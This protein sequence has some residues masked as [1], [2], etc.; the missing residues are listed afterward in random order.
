[1]SAARALAHHCSGCQ[2][3]AP[4]RR[5]TSLGAAS[6]VSLRRHVP[7]QPQ[8][9]TQS[10]QIW[11]SASLP[12]APAHTP[13]NAAGD[14]EVCNAAARKLLQ[15]ADSNL[16]AIRQWYCDVASVRAILHKACSWGRRRQRRKRHVHRRRR[17]LHER[18]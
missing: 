2:S 12:D 3:R 7:S 14:T 5:A 6:L 16:T 4:R 15:A 9:L 1:M 13:M 17:R 8:P 11:S 10:L 18:L